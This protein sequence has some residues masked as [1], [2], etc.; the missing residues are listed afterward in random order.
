[1]NIFFTVDEAMLAPMSASI[2]SIC[3]FNKRSDINLWIAHGELTSNDMDLLRQFLDGLEVNFNLIKVE[4]GSFQSVRE[5]LRKGHVSAAALYRCAMGTLLP[6]DLSKLL[7]ID[8]DTL[9]LNSLKKLY[10]TDLKG[11][12][13]GV[14]NTPMSHLQEYGVKPSDYFNSG[15]MLIDIRQWRE[16]NIQ[17]RLFETFK[18]SPTDLIWWDQCALNIELKDRTI[19]LSSEFNYIFDIE[20]VSDE[21][22]IPTIL[23]FAGGIKPW[24]DPLRHPWGG[25]YIEMSAH[26]PWYIGDT[27]PKPKLER[28]IANFVERHGGKTRK[29]FRRIKTK[30]VK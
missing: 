24:H 10:E 6:D 15:V 21:F 9:V 12:I 7:Y 28:R 30:F 29:I 14:V 25:I 22:G 1:M 13:A 4:E 5:T 2:Y 19:K 17:E 18:N 16:L 27:L 11:A 23:H 26:T 3:L 8:C 20:N